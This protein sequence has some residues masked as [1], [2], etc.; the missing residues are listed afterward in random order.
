M[1]IKLETVI[2]FAMF[3]ITCYAWWQMYRMF[4]TVKPIVDA[5]DLVKRFSWI[6]S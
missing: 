5:V 4:E 1:R 2:V 6:G 3:A